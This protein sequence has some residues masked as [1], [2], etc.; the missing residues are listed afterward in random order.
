MEATSGNTHS[1]RSLTVVVLSTFPSRKLNPFILRLEQGLIF[2]PQ[3]R[4]VL[5]LALPSLHRARVRN[6]HYW[7]ATPHP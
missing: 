2:I 5:D 1:I 4:T 3:R 6:A 7:F